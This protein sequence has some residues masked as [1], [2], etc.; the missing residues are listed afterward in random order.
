MNNGLKMWMKDVQISLEQQQQTNKQKNNNEEAR[1]PRKR[2][3]N[4]S[5]DI[6]FILF[7]MGDNLFWFPRR[8]SGLTNNSLLLTVFHTHTQAANS[9]ALL[10]LWKCTAF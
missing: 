4:T 7:F 1:W 3:G 5:L 9:R 8:G 2:K 6:I 10:A